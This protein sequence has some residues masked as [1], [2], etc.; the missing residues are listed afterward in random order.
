MRSL[1]VYESMFGNTHRVAEVIGAGFP[2]GS[3]VEV[4][5]VH[6]APDRLPDDRRGVL[7]ESAS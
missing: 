5:S 2:A 3:T 1:V 7:R 4:A 6:D